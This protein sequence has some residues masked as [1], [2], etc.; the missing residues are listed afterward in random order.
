M[1]KKRKPRLAIES[2]R[3]A[4]PSVVARVITKDSVRS[5]RPIRK[6]AVLRDFVVK[7]REV[8]NAAKLSVFESIFVPIPTFGHGS[9]VMIKRMFISSASGREGIY[10]KSKLCG[11]CRQ[12]AQL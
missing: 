1:V 11:T 10:A 3:G 6:N 5:E 4:Q 7:K 2:I 8:S 9:W 12:S